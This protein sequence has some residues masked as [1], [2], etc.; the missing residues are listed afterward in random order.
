M[1]FCRSYC[2][3]VYLIESSLVSKL[4]FSSKPAYTTIS[5]LGPHFVF[6]LP[7]CGAPCSTR[8]GVTRSGTVCTVAQPGATTSQAAVRPPQPRSIEYAWRNVGEM[9][10]PS[11]S[12]P[13]ARLSLSPHHWATPT[14]QFHQDTQSP[15]CYTYSTLR[16]LYQTLFW[17]SHKKP[18]RYYS[19]KCLPHFG[20]VLM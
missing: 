6:P 17:V 7:S 19:S 13:P 4:T 10:S 15:P 9:T 12:I 5:L 2:S 20:E 3:C 14:H 18:C 16:W 1:I 8:A 11:Y